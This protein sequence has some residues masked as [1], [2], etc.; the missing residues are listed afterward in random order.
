MFGAAVPS[1]TPAIGP[2]DA[3]GRVVYLQWVLGVQ[4]VICLALGLVVARRTGRPLLECLLAGFLAGAAPLAGYVVMLAAWR[5]LPR[6][7]RPR[8]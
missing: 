5:W 4:L 7:D 2:A 8:S 6:V 3:L 1:P